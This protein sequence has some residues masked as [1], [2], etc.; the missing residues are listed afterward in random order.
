[1]ERGGV[2]REIDNHCSLLDLPHVITTL[3]GLTL[4][5]KEL[6]PIV[7][8]DL[9]FTITLS[10]LGNC[11]RKCDISSGNNCLH[12]KYKYGLDRAYGVK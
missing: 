3:V 2:A 9:Q 11:A 6:R 1:M 4:I 8:L 5:D 7:A 12:V 10:F